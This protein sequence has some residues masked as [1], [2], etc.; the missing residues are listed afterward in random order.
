M[1]A[2]LKLGAISLATSL[3]IILLLRFGSSLT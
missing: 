3:V 2:P 1:G